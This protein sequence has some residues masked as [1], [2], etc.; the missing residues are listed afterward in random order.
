MTEMI[1]R[2]NQQI[3]NRSL[4]IGLFSGPVIYSLYFVTG[5]LF[6]EATCTADLLHFRI[7]GLEAVSFWLIVLTLGAAVVTGSCM[8]M[9]LGNWRRTQRDEESR[10]PERSYPPFMAFVGAWL[11]G[12]FTL[13]IL[14]TGVPSFFLV[15]CDWI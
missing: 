10:H 3:S 9:A 6:A 14:L 2:Q 12:L 7:L 15:I 11:N 8:V 1:V 5:Y 4:W 13:F